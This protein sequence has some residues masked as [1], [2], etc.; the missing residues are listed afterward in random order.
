MPLPL[1]LPWFFFENETLT[2]PKRLLLLLRLLWL[3]TE[4]SAYVGKDLR[5]DREGHF[6]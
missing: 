2:S 5:S 1:L 3:L 4:D 6:H